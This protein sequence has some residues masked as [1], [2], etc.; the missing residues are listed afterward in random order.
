MLELQIET[1]S[2]AN[3]L[4]DLVYSIQK[5]DQAAFAILYRLKVS[6]VYATCLR[7]LADPIYAEEITQEVF[8]RVWE[9]IGTY[10]D[11]GVFD[12]W[13]KKVTVNAVLSDLRLNKRRK[14]RIITTD[15]PSSYEKII[16]SSAPETNMDLEYA[17][18]KLPEQA[19]VIFILF[20]IEG[21]K[22]KEIANELG[23]AVGTSKTQLHRACRILREVLSK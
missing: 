6:R 10:R 11:E 15:D 20:D 22:H 14:E 23:I 8:V 2:N 9:R 5:G 3:N 12:G 21:Y 18:A 13:L 4:A 16:K 7:M 19:R 1:H 17:I